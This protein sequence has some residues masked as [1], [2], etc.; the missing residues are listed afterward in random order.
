MSPKKPSKKIDDPLECLK[1]LALN[2]RS[3]N[4]ELPWNPEIFGRDIDIPFYIHM[5]DCVEIYSGEDEMN[6]THMQFWIM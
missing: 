6:I 3:K 2:M 4:I 1:E 5:S